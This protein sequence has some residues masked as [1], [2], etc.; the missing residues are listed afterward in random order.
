[1]TPDPLASISHTSMVDRATMNAIVKYGP[2]LPAILAV[3]ADGALVRLDELIAWE[4]KLAAD[5]TDANQ[6]GVYADWLKEHG[7]LVREAQVR[8]DVERIM[9]A[10]K[11][12]ISWAVRHA[13]VRQAEGNGGGLGAIELHWEALVIGIGPPATD[14]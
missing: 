13:Q 11:S 7:F 4:E 2:H 5:M 9:T 1:M 8:A 10:G 14:E 6:R 12:A 3:L